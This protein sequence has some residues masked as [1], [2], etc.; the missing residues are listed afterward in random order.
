MKFSEKWYSY[1]GE[2]S[3][4]EF[5]ESF[6]LSN[7]DQMERFRKIISLIPSDAKSVLDVGCGEGLFL[8]LLEKERRI[9]GMGIEISEKK[10]DYARKHLNV[11][12]ELGDASNLKFGDRSFDV[13]TALEVLE[14]LPYGI[15]EEA[16]KEIDRVAD[17]YIIISVPY[18]EQRMFI[19]CPYCKTK[20]NPNYHLRTFKEKNIINLFPSFKLDSVE[21][22][23]A[24][25]IYQNLL[26]RV[27]QIL[28]V[29][30]NIW[31]MCP[32]CGYSEFPRKTDNKKDSGIY[33]EGI[34]KKLTPL[35]KLISQIIFKRPRWLVGVYKRR[36]KIL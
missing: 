15:Y 14:H 26:F 24:T 25:Y 9:K 13:V 18:D 11:N 3:V 28:K 23:G 4:E 27:G 30:I 7:P 31:Y 1:Y 5:V 22:I 36:N 16:L 19:T 17:K 2:Y 29:K 6:I 32:A 34:R 35:L 8:Y 21:R 33:S 12:A 20:F 10:I